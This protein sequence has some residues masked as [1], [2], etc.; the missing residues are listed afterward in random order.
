MKTQTT[1]M[2][3][4]NTLYNEITLFDFYRYKSQ[5]GMGTRIEFGRW[6][7]TRTCLVKLSRRRILR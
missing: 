6:R 3:K 7:H 2:G 4:I 5:V 1:K